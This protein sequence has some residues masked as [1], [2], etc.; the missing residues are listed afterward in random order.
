[1]PKHCW[2]FQKSSLKDVSNCSSLEVKSFVQ[3]LGGADKP[4][5]GRKLPLLLLAIF[6]LNFHVILKST[7]RY[8]FFLN[9]KRRIS[10]TAIP[11]FNCILQANCTVINR[12]RAK[13]V[14]V[15][16]YWVFLFVFF[17]SFKDHIPFCLNTYGQILTHKW[18]KNKVDVFQVMLV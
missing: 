15:M 13:Q 6:P 12:S 1:M 11:L 10:W 17:V 7:A 2:L 4:C 5:M 3:D 18:S 14:W 16:W 8:N 9:L